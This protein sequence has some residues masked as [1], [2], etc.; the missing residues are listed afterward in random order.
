[1]NTSWT[2]SN[3]VVLNSNYCI[4]VQ[5]LIFSSD[6]DPPMFY[7]LVCLNFHYCCKWHALPLV[8]QRSPNLETLVCQWTHCC[9]LG[10]SASGNIRI[11]E[12]H[13]VPE[14]L[15]SQLTTFN[16]EGFVW[17]EDELE[18]VRYILKNARFLKKLTI[19]SSLPDSDVKLHLLKELL[20][21]PKC[22]SKCK[23]A[24]VYN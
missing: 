15:S 10:R 1:V 22:S 12:P 13:T 23:I 19:T 11:N 2:G 9:H 3:I 7:N 5:C 18:V 14:C 4:V 20:V 24:F 8:L 6:L 16:F 21:F 17:A